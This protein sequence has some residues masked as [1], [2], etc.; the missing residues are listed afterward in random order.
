MHL[1]SVLLLLPIILTSIPALSSEPIDIGS[2]L[3]PMVDRYL[4]ERLDG[5]T[6]TLNRPT[7]REVA[8]VFDKPWEG[9]TS[10]YPTVFRD[11]DIFRMYYRG[12]HYDEATGKTTHPEFVCYAESRDGI[13]W[14]KPELGLVEFE[15]SKQN[16]IVHAGIG[17]HDFAPMKDANP[18]CKP[19]EQYKAMARGD[20]GLYA[21]KS[22]DG[23][24]WSL[25]DPKPVITRGAFDSQNLAFWDPVRA[26]YVDFHRGFRDGVRDIMTA[27]STDFRHWTEPVWLEYPGAPREHLYTNQIAP[28]YRAPHIYFGFPKRFVPT[29]RTDAHRHPGVSDGVFMTSRDGRHFHRFGE[30]IVRPG[31]QQ[32]RWVNRNNMTAWGIL[33]TR[34]AIPGTP[35]ELSIY[36]SEGY[37]KG[38]SCQLRRYTS[39]IDGFVSVRAPLAGGELVTRPIT[40]EG[41]RLAIN[42]STSAAGS[43][44]VEIQDAAGRPIPGFALADCEEVFGDALE[45]VIQWKGSSEVSPLVGRPIRLRFVMSDADLYALQFK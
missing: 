25:L 32:E 27:T 3:E 20:G 26:C 6:L 2:R 5:A 37:Y 13:R 7:P 21:L 24:R 17:S 11:G 22:A 12:S 38:E 8:I 14:T 35:D 19:D 15:G 10:A 1:R 28:Y 44:R 42:F 36:S 16:N 4:I 45:R 34:S 39:R 18:D 33:V 41:T 31:L 23:L 30:A 40:F 9:N 43:I 29:R